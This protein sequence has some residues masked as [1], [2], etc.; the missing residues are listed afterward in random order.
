MVHCS[1]TRSLD[2][3]RASGDVYHMEGGVNYM[4]Y[5]NN[6]LI[7]NAVARI[8]TGIIK[9]NNAISNAIYVYFSSW[10]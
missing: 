10:A 1:Y 9:L 4:L 5:E 7:M 3:F 8:Y 2:V 6:V